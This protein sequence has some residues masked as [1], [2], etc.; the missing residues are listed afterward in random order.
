MGW[1]IVG[2]TVQVAGVGLAL[3]G[4]LQTWRRHG[5][6]I[7]SFL[8]SWLPGAYRG[9]RPTTR[10]RCRPGYREILALFEQCVDTGS[11]KSS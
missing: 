11:E 4:M 8:A 1:T 9:R 5:G 3:R 7:L 2:L 10:S 6:S